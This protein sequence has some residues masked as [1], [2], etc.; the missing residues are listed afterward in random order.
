MGEDAER[1][2]VCVGR[3]SV[4]IGRAVHVFVLVELWVSRQ[5]ALFACSQYHTERF[6]MTR[7]EWHMSSLT[8]SV[9][10]SHSGTT[11]GLEKERTAGTLDALNTITVT[12]HTEQL[13]AE[14]T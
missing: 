8:P 1:L 5:S 14:Q 4:A 6:A 11:H 7:P 12:V 10:F 13:L 2:P 3:L 9:A